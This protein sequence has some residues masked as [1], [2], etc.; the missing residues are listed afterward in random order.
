VGHFLGGPSAQDRTVL[1]IAT[2]SRH[3]GL[4]L[5]IARANYPEQATLVAGAVVIYLVF[6]LVL[7]IPYY[8]WRHSAPRISRP[9]ASV[10]FPPGLAGRRR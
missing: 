4:A 2:S 8:R 7:A 6:R 5:A 10:H 1:A 9:Q 3:P